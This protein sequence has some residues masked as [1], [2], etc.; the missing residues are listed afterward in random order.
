MCLR[1]C[2]CKKR[3]FVRRN[4]WVCVCV[5]AHAQRLKFNFCCH[6]WEPFFVLN[7][8]FYLSLFVVRIHAH[9]NAMVH[10]FKSSGLMPSVNV[11]PEAVC[12]FIPWLMR[13]RLP[14]GSGVNWLSKAAGQWSPGFFLSSFY[15]HWDYRCILPHGTASA[16]AAMNWTQNLIFMQQVGH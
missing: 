9:L 12:Q 4:A 8:T 16:V 10:V 3:M 6:L 14:V 13:H 15:Q 1:M 5:S 11:P 2:L 7:I